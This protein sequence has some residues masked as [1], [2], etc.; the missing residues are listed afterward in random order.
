VQD[1]P[2][3][4]GERKKDGTTDLDEIPLLGMKPNQVLCLTSSSKMWKDNAASIGN[5]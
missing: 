2:L 4:I 5:A 1:D 3:G